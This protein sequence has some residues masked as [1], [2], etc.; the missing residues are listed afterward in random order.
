V[1]ATGTR[2]RASGAAPGSGISYLAADYRAIGMPANRQLD[3]EV[4]SFDDHARG[5]LAAA[6]AALRA[7]A[8]TERRFDRLLLRMGF[9]P[10]DRCHRPRAGRRQPAPH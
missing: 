2:H 1:L 4:D 9:P 5:G 3:Q 10:V 8:G 7:E 6:E